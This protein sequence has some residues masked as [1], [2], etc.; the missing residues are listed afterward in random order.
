MI[1]VDKMSIAFTPSYPQ[2][3]LSTLQNLPKKI[4]QSREVK[5]KKQR[6]A[7][8]HFKCFLIEALLLNVFFLLIFFVQ[9][10]E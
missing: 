3:T 2:I 4:K 8:K 10:I 5:E 6:S 1:G 7:R 9:T